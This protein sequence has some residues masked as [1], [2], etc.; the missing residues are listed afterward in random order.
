MKIADANRASRRVSM[1]TQLLFHHDPRIGYSRLERLVQHHIGLLDGRQR[2][3]DHQVRLHPPLARAHDACAQSG[4]TLH[5]GCWRLRSSGICRVARTGRRDRALPA[6][7]PR[8][9]ATP[10]RR[11]MVHSAAMQR[12]S[13][14]Q[15]AQHCRSA[16]GRSAS[17]R[18]V[19]PSQ[20][21][22]SAFPAQHRP[23][24]N[25]PPP[26]PRGARAP[27]CHRRSA[28]ATP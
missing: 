1:A 27:R 19:A 15:S 18:P 11:R 14:H 13:E 23:R 12:R 5:A 4:N 20:F 17:P 26:A 6:P 22:T 10:E 24:H 21:P 25:S 9:A 7:P 28:A 16:A 2:P 8:A 3:D